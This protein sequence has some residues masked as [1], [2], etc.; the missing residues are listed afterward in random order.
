MSGDH[1]IQIRL[2]DFRDGGKEDELPVDAADA[3]AGDRALKGEI[4]NGQGCAGGADRKHVRR[5]CLVHGEGHGDNL[6]VVSQAFGE[7]WA[8][9][10]VDKAADEHSLFGR[11]ASSLHKPAGDLADGVFPLL[12]I[13]DE[14]K[15]IDAL[16]RF[17][18]HGCRTEDDGLA[19]TKEDCAAGLLCH[20]ARFDAEGLAPNL[21]GVRVNH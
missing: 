14:R 8:N 4:G 20:A 13:A 9:G 18:R 2:L 6:N 5:T 7:E 12:I 19:H 1:E 10:A 3:H 21:E 16:A 17:G 15:K 11:A